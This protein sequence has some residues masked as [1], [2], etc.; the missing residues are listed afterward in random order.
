MNVIS[1]RMLKLFWK[2]H[3]RAETPLKIWHAQVSSVRWAGPQDV[4]TMFG[5][6]VDFLADNRVVFDIAGNN[7]RLVATIAYAPYYRVMVKFVGTHAEYDKI[8][9]GSIQ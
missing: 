8:H 7:Y 1:K 4:K 6:T 2:K 9:A 5:A 3:A